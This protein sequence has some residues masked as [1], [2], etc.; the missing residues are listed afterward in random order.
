VSICIPATP[1][2]IFA[3][4]GDEDITYAKIIDMIKK[5]IG[6]IIKP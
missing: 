6:T 4:V 2:Y 3:A 5:I 1:P